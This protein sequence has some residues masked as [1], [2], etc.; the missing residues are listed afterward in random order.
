MSEIPKAT[1]GDTQPADTIGA[2]DKTDHLRSTR[3]TFL[4][5]GLASFASLLLPRGAQAQPGFSDTAPEIAANP[6]AAPVPMADKVLAFMHDK[7]PADK[8]PQDADIE[9]STDT[10]PQRTRVIG[11]LSIQGEGDRRI[12]ISGAYMERPDGSF[13]QRQVIVRLFNAPEPI[14]SISPDR[15]QATISPYVNLEGMDGDWTFYKGSNTVPSRT[16]RTR[17]EGDT[18]SQGVMQFGNN[19]EKIGN[20]QIQI[21]EHTKG[22]MEFTQGTGFATALAQSR[23]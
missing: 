3:R 10:S 21:A 16:E 9:W 13:L 7:I 18:Y 2:P 11:K 8:L 14:P 20:L 17:K 22:T 12:D 19:T 23:G 15:V 5:A 6:D 1:S 4:A